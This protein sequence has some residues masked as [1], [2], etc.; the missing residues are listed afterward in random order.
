MRDSHL[1]RAI[2][3]KRFWES[4]SQNLDGMYPYPGK[5]GNF[6]FVSCPIRLEG[7]A[8]AA[9]R[10]LGHQGLTDQSHRLS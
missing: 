6:M 1:S 5:A 2:R 9:P 10:F 3:Q 8:N 4:V 7:G